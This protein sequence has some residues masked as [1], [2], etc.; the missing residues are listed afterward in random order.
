MFEQMS[1]ET[2]Q[3]YWWIIIALLGGALVFLL[4][5]QGGQTLFNELAKSD[6]E[7]S[8]LVNIIGHKWEFTFTTLVVFGGAFFASFPLFYSTSFGGAYW[9]WMI[10]LFAFIVQAVSYEY[11][12]KKGNFLGSKIYDAFLYVNGLLAPLLLGIAVSTFFTGSPFSVGKERIL[13]VGQNVEAVISR[14]DTP[15]HGLDALWNGF[16]GAWFQNLMLGLAVFFLA[17]TNA[18][19]YIRKMTDEPSIL[20]RIAKKL[21]INAGLFLV[22]FLIWLIRLMFIPGFA[23]EP[24]TGKIFLE[25]YKYWHNLVQNPFTA[26]LLLIGV[27]LV[28]YGLYL[29]IFKVLDKAFWYSAAGTVL[30]VMALFF[31]AGFNHTAY[32]PSITDLQS[33]LTIHNSSSSRF[34]LIVMSYVSLMVPFVVAYIVWAWKALDVHKY[35][36]KEIKQEEIKY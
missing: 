32:Y 31:L 5:V 3:A 4:L 19:L 10:I 6:D 12:K 26:G 13:R 18:L 8:V 29:G 14:W 17:R 24:E 23:V 1:Y 36:V 27:L 35:D 30:T 7:K 11:R 15:W 16:H 33:S 25:D 34:T 22:F 21:K 28:L 2:L 20:Q 9:V